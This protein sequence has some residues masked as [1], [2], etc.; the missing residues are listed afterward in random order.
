[1]KNMTRRFITNAFALALAANGATAFAQNSP[2][3]KPQEKKVERQIWIDTAAKTFDVQV[4][5][6]GQ[7]VTGTPHVMAFTGTGSPQDS[8]SYSFVTSEVGTTNKLVKGAPYSA[9]IVNEFVQTLANG[10][11]IVR[12][13]T[14]NVYRDGQGRTRREMSLAPIGVT[15]I[16]AEL[17]PGKTVIITDPVEGFVYLVDDKSR[18]VRRTRF[19]TGGTASVHVM[20]AGAVGGVGGAVGGSPIASGVTV[21]TGNV[22]TT[23]TTQTTTTE[24]PRKINVSRGVLQG[25]A[26]SKVQPTYPTIAK[27]SRAAGEVQVQVTINETGDVI[28]AEILSGHPLLRDTSL[29]AAR[30]WKFKPTELSGQPVKVQGTLSFNFTLKDDENNSSGFQTGQPG[31]H[32]SDG[33]AVHQVMNIKTERNTRTL[34]KQ[35]IEGIECEGTKSVETIPA[36]QIGN[37]QP[38]EIVTERWFSPELQLTVLSKHNDPRNGETTVRMTN[39]LRTEPDAQLFKVP[40]DYT[41][42]DGGG[43]QVF[44]RTT[45]PE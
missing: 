39:L 44:M 29:D 13:N 27:A 2:Q 7:V 34:G 36:G 1:M 6:P 22:T 25:S 35:M 26:L 32:D 45:K 14:S 42:K 15:G 24:L 8:F 38:I 19:S 10:N 37:D 33:H 40:S 12:R 9:E 3:D 5:A 18:T 31:A 41:I 21:I 4:L 20:P 28:N 17:L 11:R 43:P 30:Q 23:T 16:P